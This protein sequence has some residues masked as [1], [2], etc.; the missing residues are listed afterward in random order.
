MAN[1]SDLVN[2]LKHM[3]RE[4]KANPVW[5]LTNEARECIEAAGFPCDE[6]IY[7]VKT[8]KIENIRRKPAV[9]KEL[10]YAYLKGRKYIW[11]RYKDTEIEVLKARGIYPE[12]YRYEVRLDA[13]M[14]H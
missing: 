9:I 5:H 11:R 2:R 4:G 10:H 8:R 6:A 3:Q 1:L 13:Y 12:P 14:N 7:Q